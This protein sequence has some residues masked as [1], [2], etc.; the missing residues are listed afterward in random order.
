MNIAQLIASVQGLSAIAA[1]LLIGL[2]AMG[3]AI[4]F[5]ML[6]GKFLE[7]VARQ[8]ELSTMLMIRMFLMAG[9]VDA[10]AAISLVMGLILIFARNPFLN[11]VVK[12]VGRATTGQ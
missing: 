10:F 7:G 6:G 5:G 11:A 1:G 4:G 12:A 2:A 9:L 8:P 3:T